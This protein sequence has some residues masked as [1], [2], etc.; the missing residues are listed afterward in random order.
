M[1]GLGLRRP[2]HRRAR[3]LRAAVFLAFLLVLGLQLPA[4]LAAPRAAEAATPELTLTPSGS[5]QMLAGTSASYTLAAA[6]PGTA[7]AASFI[8]SQTP[9]SGR[10]E[11]VYASAPAPAAGPENLTSKAA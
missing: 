5:A 11:F 7:L 1:R 2:A 3:T 9:A 8:E 4:I 6:N 10:H